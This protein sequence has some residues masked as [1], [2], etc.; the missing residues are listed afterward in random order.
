[1]PTIMAIQPPTMPIN[2]LRMSILSIIISLVAIATNSCSVYAVET[3]Q[4]IV[5][6]SRGQSNNNNN[7]ISDNISPSD[8]HTS[9]RRVLQDDE[10]EDEETV[11]ELIEQETFGFNTTNPE[12]GKALEAAIEELIESQSQETFDFDSSS[13]EAA[14][15]S[16]EQVLAGAIDTLANEVDEKAGSTL[17]PTD[18]S[19]LNESVKELAEAVEN[20]EGNTTE[21]EE[22]EEEEEMVITTIP[23]GTIENPSDEPIEPPSEGGELGCPVCTSGLTVDPD[24][25]AAENGNSC[26]DLLNDALTVDEMSSECM[27]MKGAEILCC[28]PLDDEDED[29]LLNVP[30]PGAEE[31]EESEAEEGEGTQQFGF[32]S[33]NT[34][35]SPSADGLSDNG[36]GEEEEGPPI[37]WEQGEESASSK[38]PSPTPATEPDEQFSPPPTPKSPYVPEGTTKTPTYEPTTIE[39]WE[40][41]QEEEE[42]GEGPL[43]DDGEDPEWYNEWEVEMGPTD[44]PTPRPT[45]LYIPQEGEDPLMEEEVPDIKDFNDDVL[46]HGLGGKVGAYLDQVES[47]QEMEQDKNVQVVAGILGSL[48]LVLLLVTA[49][50]VMNHPDGLCAGCCRLTLKVICCLTRTLCLPCRAICCKGSEQAQSRRSHQ[51]MRTPFPSD[52]ELA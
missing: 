6:R 17:A 28:P 20:L 7:G 19:A 25:P 43:D 26:E 22:E 16:E 4:T 5:H 33:D 11:E 15:A 29:D 30:P 1:M 47:P 3:S 24:T 23:S 49:H 2:N 27:A 39:E 48:L 14:K 35:P 31:E 50:L 42:F 12:A 9:L 32:G 34:T 41:E 46:Y 13:P 52:L 10:E 51:P 37:T 38:S 45:A 8:K 40:E 44:K 21:N 18:E 36:G